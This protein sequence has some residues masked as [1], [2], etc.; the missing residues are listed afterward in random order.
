MTTPA[1][2]PA[3]SQS[4]LMR[5]ERLLIVAMVLLAGSWGF[6]RYTD[7]R[8]T[9]AE[10][11]ASAAEQALVLQKATDAKNE[12]TLAQVLS[13]YQAISQADHALISS[14]AAT[15]AQRQAGV[16]QNQTTDATLALPLLGNRLSEL[17]NVPNGQVS[18]DS[19][20]VILTQTGAVAVTQTLETIPALKA[21]LKDT[22]TA[23]STS[24]GAK[25]KADQ[26]IASQTDVITGL[27]T[28]AVDQDKAC[29]AE[30]TA[31]QAEGKK[32]SVKWFK[33]GFIVGFLAG[34]WT[35]HAT[36]M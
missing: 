8:A 2:T 36:G 26:V 19:S 35:G 6:S 5:H 25:A 18:V 30:V 17:G 32:N 9:S 34:L 11:K 13:Q 15:V 16:A 1:V 21:D 7:A 4:W 27:K 3:I 33:R 22:Q 23:L 14:L 28:V 29:K 20:H 31:A 10:A 24:E 12:A